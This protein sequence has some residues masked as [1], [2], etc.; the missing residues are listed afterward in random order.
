MMGIYNKQI[1]CVFLLSLAART[2]ARASDLKTFSDLYGENTDEIR[3]YYKSRFDGLQVMYGNALQSI[4]DQAQAKGDLKA[5]KAAIAEIDRFKKA[6]CLPAET[7]EN[8]ISEIRTLQE[9]YVGQFN[10][11]EAEMLARL[12][13]LTAKYEQALGRL[14]KNLTRTLELEEATAVMDERQKVKTTMNDFNTRR[15]ALLGVQV[16]GQAAPG[17]VQS[18]DEAKNKDSSPAATPVKAAGSV[19]DMSESAPAG[20]EKRI[21]AYVDAKTVGRGGN[22]KSTFNKV[23][24]MTCEVSVRITSVDVQNAPAKVMVFFVGRDSGGRQLVAEKQAREVVLDKA[25]GWVGSFTSKDIR[26]NAPYHYFYYENDTKRWVN[27]V[28]LQGWVVQVWSG[29][30]LAGK[31]ASLNQLIKYA[32]SQDLVKEI[33]LMLEGNE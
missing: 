3:A 9:A 14:Q 24:N 20:Q 7:A 25:R 31:A 28:K 10:K 21:T 1:I 8:E 2:C 19:K 17:E 29:D 22:T 32:D 11:L 26:E 12:S 13:D 6:R 4:Q 33:G 23:R 5:T 27:G 15:A 16:S 18:A 30:Q